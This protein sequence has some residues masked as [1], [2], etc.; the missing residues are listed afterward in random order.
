MK[1]AIEHAIEFFGEEHG[2]VAAAASFDR[3]GRPMY[4]RE[5]IRILGSLDP[6]CSRRLT[7]I[8]A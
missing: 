2:L 5:T 6:P 8:S 4:I 7:M 1:K 3:E